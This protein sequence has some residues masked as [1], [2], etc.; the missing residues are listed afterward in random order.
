LGP[1]HDILRAWHG[2]LAYD[3]DLIRAP[4][5]LIRGEWDGVVP[6]EDARWL[7]DAFR[8]SPMKRDIKISRATHLMHL[9]LMRTALYRETN[10]FLLGGDEP[11]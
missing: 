4:I 10:T 3:P 8:N 11:V 7:F 2:Q 9:E 1:F 6:D 5:A